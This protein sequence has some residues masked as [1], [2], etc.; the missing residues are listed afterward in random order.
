MPNA[1]SWQTEEHILNM[2]LKASM[3]VLPFAW[4]WAAVLLLIIAG[5]SA[6]EAGLGRK[7]A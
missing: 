5:G 3:A 7:A 6:W 2:A 4:G 1:A